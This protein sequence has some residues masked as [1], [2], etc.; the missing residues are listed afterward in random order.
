METTIIDKCN[1]THGRWYIPETSAPFCQNS[2]QEMKECFT[3]TNRELKTYNRC[4]DQ[5]W[6]CKETQ[7]E[8]ATFQSE[9]PGHYNASPLIETLVLNYNDT[10]SNVSME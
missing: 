1:C 9:W 8:A 5:L 4:T 7:Y 3:R 2:S 6:A 10:I